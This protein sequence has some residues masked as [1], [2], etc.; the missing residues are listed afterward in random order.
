M[1]GII[2]V[3]VYSDGERPII[4][5][6]VSYADISRARF[7]ELFELNINAS[8]IMYYTGQY[9]FIGCSSGSDPIWLFNINLTDGTKLWVPA[10]QYDK[11]SAQINKIAAAIDKLNEE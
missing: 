1:I 9:K 8:S 5:N 2:K 7:H 10:F 3:E 6:N 11:L 4:T